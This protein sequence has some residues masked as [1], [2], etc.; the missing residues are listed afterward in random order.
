M[1]LPWNR[2]RWCEEIQLLVVGRW[3]CLATI[4]YRDLLHD[5]QQIESMLIPKTIITI[6]IFIIFIFVLNLPKEEREKKRREGRKGTSVRN[7]KERKKKKSKNREIV[8]W[9]EEN[10]DRIWNPREHAPLSP[11]RNE[12]RFSLWKQKSAPPFPAH[13][14]RWWGQDWNAES[15]VMPRVDGRR[16]TPT[17]FHIN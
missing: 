1:P 4:A 17:R 2:F 10:L 11:P 14:R 8:K 6:F 3:R 5:G 15:H 7:K 9:R 16:P 13:T 12:R